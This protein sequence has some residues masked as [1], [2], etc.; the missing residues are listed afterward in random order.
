MKKNLKEK[1]A[2][3]QTEE[4]FN[5]LLDTVTFLMKYENRDHVAV[6][7]ANRVMHLP[8]D[9]GWTTLEYLTGCVQKSIAYE[10]AQSI[11]RSTAHKFQVADLEKTIKAEPQN[12]QARD[13]LEKLANEGS[14]V[15]KQ[16]V[17]AL[18]LPAKPAPLPAS[19]HAIK[20]ANPNLQ[21]HGPY[22]N[23]SA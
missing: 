20:P 18:D 17:A 11:G 19:V 1:I 6:V 14:L 22:P 10:I 15:A 2:L 7:V 13:Q 8:A 12:Q 3:P 9:Q 5:T 16:A 23:G 21:E 4:Q